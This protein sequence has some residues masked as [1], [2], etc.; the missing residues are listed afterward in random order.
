MKAVAYLGAFVLALATFVAPLQANGS[1]TIEFDRVKSRVIQCGNDP[2][3]NWGCVTYDY[4]DGSDCMV[5]DI[6]GAPG[7]VYTHGCGGN[8][9]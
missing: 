9:E 6:E 1:Q 3:G 2:D 8:Q 5:I 4:D 7:G